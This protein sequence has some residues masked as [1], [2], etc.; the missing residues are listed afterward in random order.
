MA[1]SG[2]GLAVSLAVMFRWDWLEEETVVA[3]LSQRAWQKMKHAFSNV[4]SGKFG[5]ERRRREA[6]I[7]PPRF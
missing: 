4:L 3:D 6:F 2:V 7:L 5:E 1:W